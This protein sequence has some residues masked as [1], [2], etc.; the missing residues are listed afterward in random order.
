M[1]VG[2]VIKVRWPENHRHASYTGHMREYIPE[3]TVG[4]ITKVP[5]YGQQL[6]KVEFFLKPGLHFW[7]ADRWM[8]PVS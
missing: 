7:L 2:T 8:E 5:E 1:K 6:Y 4:V 3:G